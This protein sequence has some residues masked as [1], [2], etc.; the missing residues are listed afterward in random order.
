MGLY[1]YLKCWR[2]CYSNVMQTAV[3]QI[4]EETSFFVYTARCYVLDHFSWNIYKFVTV[5]FF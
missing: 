5:N 4:E 2:A 1:C 3:R